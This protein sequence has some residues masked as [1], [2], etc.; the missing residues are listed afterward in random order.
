MARS[1]SATARVLT[2]PAAQPRRRRRRHLARR[3]PWPGDVTPDEIILP[4]LDDIADWINGPRSRAR[5]TIAMAVGATLA[6][7]LAYLMMLLT[8]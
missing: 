1:T 6:L 3:I 7:D 2:E 5:K 4:S 8:G